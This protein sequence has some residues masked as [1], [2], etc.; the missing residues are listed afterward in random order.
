MALRRPAKKNTGFDADEVTEKLWLGS[1]DAA[2]NEGALRQNNI[3]SIVSVVDEQQLLPP[4]YEDIHAV[5]YSVSDSLDEDILRILPHCCNYLDEARRE[6]GVLVHCKL[7]QSR[8]AVVVI[9]YLMVHGRTLDNALAELRLERP[10]I[11]PNV[12]FMKQLELWEMMHC[13]MHGNT[14]AHS[15]YRKLKRE[16]DLPT[17]LHIPQ[18]E[19]VK[20]K[21]DSYA[22]QPTRPQEELLVQPR[23]PEADPEAPLQRP[24]L[25]R[26]WAEELKWSRL[27]APLSGAV[28]MTGLVTPCSSVIEPP[29]TGLGYPSSFPRWKP[30]V[31]S[32]PL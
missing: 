32:T 22:V 3:R 16:A 7:G 20:I 8:S 31:G 17:H 19:L 21:H 11:N 27:F 25:W 2:L 24:S 5:Q 9:A 23:G 26:M 15:L 30:R 28:P 12:N 4:P 10:R 13:E 14:K 18:M 6:G 29:P 1:F